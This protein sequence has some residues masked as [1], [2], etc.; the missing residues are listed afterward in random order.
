MS[1]SRR[2][3]FSTAS[4]TSTWA[5]SRPPSRSGGTSSSRNTR[6][7]SNRSTRIEPGMKTGSLLSHLECGLCGERLDA[8]RLWNLCPKCGKPLLAR[9]DLDEARA[10][11]TREAIARRE[12][13]MWR[14]REMLPVRD[15][16][17]ELSLGEGFTPL[18][19]K[20]RLEAEAGL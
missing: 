2:S 7:S 14:Y 13:T 20:A 6:T 16:A 18:E 11:V 9:Y 5:R 3:P 17:Y 10:K 4:S 15:D 12:P 8:D 1:G 19:R